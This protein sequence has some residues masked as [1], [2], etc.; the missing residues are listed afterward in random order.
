MNYM[1]PLIAIAAFFLLGIAFFIVGKDDFG[2]KRV[3]EV[4]GDLKP[5]EK[6]II[7]M[8]SASKNDSSEKN[9]GLVGADL[10]SE[11]DSVSNVSE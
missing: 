4:S 8:E 6:N 7:N 9:K 3:K 1:L 2:I 5:T 10:S 11:I